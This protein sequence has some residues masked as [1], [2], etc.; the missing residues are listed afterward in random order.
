[1]TDT[2]EIERELREAP[3]FILNDGQRYKRC[4]TTLVDDILD[5][6]AELQRERDAAMKV[7]LAAEVHVEN[8]RPLDF[9]N[10]IGATAGLRR[11]FPHLF[12][13]TGGKK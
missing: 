11:D 2:T 9:A 6:L 10:L 12:A 7:V 3:E 1:M 13:E 8:D 5:K 4:P